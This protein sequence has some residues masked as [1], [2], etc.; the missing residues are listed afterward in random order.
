MPLIMLICIP[1]HPVEE[2]ALFQVISVARLEEFVKWHLAQGG[3][4]GGVRL[5]EIVQH[6]RQGMGAALLQYDLIRPINIKI[7]HHRRIELENI[8]WRF[9]RNV[10]T[11]EPLFPVGEVG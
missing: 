7:F 10:M 5:V 11:Q 9:A 8:L 3:D 2:G 6:F 1:R 4:D